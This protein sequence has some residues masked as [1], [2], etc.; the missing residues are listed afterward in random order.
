MHVT[1]EMLEGHSHIY[2]LAKRKVPPKKKGDKP[3]DSNKENNASEANKGN[4]E[5]ISKDQNGN[6]DDKDAEDQDPDH[7]NDQ[8]YAE[9]KNKQA[10]VL[11][12]FLTIYTFSRGYRK[13]DQA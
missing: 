8:R 5:F 3:E 13:R 4:D 7:G 1:L 11:G 2:V 10:K 12:S 6:P 9:G